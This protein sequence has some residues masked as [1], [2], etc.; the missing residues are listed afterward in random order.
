[1]VAPPTAEIIWKYFS[2][3]NTAKERFELLGSL[4]RDLNTQVNVISRKDI[5]MLYLHHVLHS[6]AL[7]KAIQFKSGD[8]ILDI[9]TGGGFPGIPLA[10]FY[11]QC[12]FTLIDG[13]K[14]KIAVVQHV[15]EKLSLS[16]VTAIPVR[17]EEL[18][19]TFDFVV[20]RAVA[21]TEKLI[22]WGERLLKT[23]EKDSHG[24]FLFLKGGD[25][26]EEIAEV[27]KP[28]AQFPIGR[29]F[30]ETYFEEKYILHI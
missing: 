21:R 1:M 22:N 30:E 4:Y 14:K 10:I 17:V 13:T 20:S 28:V 29:Y 11:P 8:K 15:I 5:D 27:R 19:G 6:L 9:G 24:G 12:H 25:L 16:N 2:V 26:R 23:R 3:D 18:N 7:P